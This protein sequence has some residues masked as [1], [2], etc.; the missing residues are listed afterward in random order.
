MTIKKAKKSVV[1]KQRAKLR[2]MLRDERSR[3]VNACADEYEKLPA[4]FR[5]LLSDITNIDPAK[6]LDRMTLTER[7]KLRRALERLEKRVDDALR[8]VRKATALDSR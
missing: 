3:V 5:A 2:E 1:N 7:A 4:A 6:R 8:I